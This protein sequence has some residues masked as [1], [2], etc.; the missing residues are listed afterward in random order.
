MP[1]W[2]LA[3]CVVAAVAL[4]FGAIGLG[5]LSDDYTLRNMAQ[6]DGLGSG[7]GWF[8]RPVP[9]LLWRGLLAAADTL[10]HSTSSTCCSMA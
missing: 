4:Y 10:L 7:T 5:F 2:W 1:H 9:L 8:F 3:V 6:S